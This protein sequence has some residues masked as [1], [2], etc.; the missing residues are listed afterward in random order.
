M[1]NAVLQMFPPNVI[2]VGIVWG[3]VEIVLA[4]IAGAWVYRE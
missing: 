4:S 1:G 3:L 2:L